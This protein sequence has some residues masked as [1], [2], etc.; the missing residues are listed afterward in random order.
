MPKGQAERQLSEFI[1]KFTP[2][3]AKSIRT[4]RAK[5]RGFMPHAEFVS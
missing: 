3:M 5:M 4:A 2:E 1:A